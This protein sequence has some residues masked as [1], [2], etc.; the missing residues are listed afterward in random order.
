MFKLKTKLIRLWIIKYNPND[1]PQ[2]Q[3]GRGDSFNQQTQ[4]QNAKS[5]KEFIVKDVFLVD[6][7]PVKRAPKIKRV[8]VE[9]TQKFYCLDPIAV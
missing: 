1:E 8:L 9:L 7:D 2:D 5:I 6:I 4:Y 3:K